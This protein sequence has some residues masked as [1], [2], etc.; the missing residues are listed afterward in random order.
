MMQL[1]YEQELSETWTGALPGKTLTYQVC[2]EGYAIDLM[3]MV[4]IPHVLVK[5][6][7]TAI[8]H[9]LNDFYMVYDAAQEDHGLQQVQIKR[10][11]R[12]YNLEEEDPLVKALKAFRLAFMTKFDIRAHASKAE[13]EK[14]LT[15]Q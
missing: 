9:Y 8:G 3:N 12:D 7:E 5:S 11:I 6:L 15:K 14:P 1:Y 13:T 4:K 2:I 10:A